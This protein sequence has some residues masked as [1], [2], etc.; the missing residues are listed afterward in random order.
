M[1]PCLGWHGLWGITQ[2]VKNPEPSS[3][4]V[5]HEERFTDALR[6]TGVILL[7]S[8]GLGMALER[9]D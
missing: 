6:D 4:L 1:C 2:H 5:L 3:T 7:R 8:G 9:C